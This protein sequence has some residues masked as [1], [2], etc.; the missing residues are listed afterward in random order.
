[1]TIRATLSSR[2]RAVTLATGLVLLLVAATAVAANNSTTLPNGAQLSVSVDAPADGAQLLADGGPLPVAVSGTAGIGLGDPKATIVYVFDASGSTTAGGGACG[3]VLACEQAFFTGLNT[4]ATSGGSVNQ[5][6]LVAFGVDAVQADMTSAGGDDLLGA[7]GDANTVISSITVAVG[8][9]QVGQY[10]PKG[11]NASGT[12]FAAALQQALGVL[13]ASTDPSK[14]VVFASDGF[15]NL[16]TLTDFNDAVAAIAATGAVVN[17]VAIGASSACTGGTTGTLAGLAVNGGTCYAVTDPN[18]LPD[19]IPALIGS[20]LE[21]VEMSVDGGTPVAVATTPATPQ[22]GHAAVAYSTSTAGLDPGRHD[23]CATA[24]GTDVTGGSA[25]TTACV[26]VGVYDLELAPATATNELGSDDT[27]T[28]TATLQGPAGAVDGY[29]VSFSVGGQNA[30]AA[31][32][33]VPADCRTNAGGQV[34]FTYSVPIAQSSLGVDTITA[35]VTLAD[36]AGETDTEQVTK[37]WAD[38]TAPVV[39]C[40]PTTNPSGKNTPPAGSNPKSGQNPDGFY[41]LTAV[42]AVDPSPLV[43]IADTGSGFVAGPY[44]SGT[45]IKLVQAPG[46]TPSARPGPGAIDWHVTLKGD[47]S[48]TATDASGNTSTATCRVP[49]PPK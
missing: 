14:F 5:V 9:Y 23:I 11:G 44:P 7:P 17:S 2:S 34:T 31:G 33:C 10:T 22:P 43:T 40:A 13:T 27:H 4:A 18:D 48:V 32:A 1:M 20:T 37:T 45:T 16:G 8:P 25:D 38:T 46:A 15:S 24:F 49:P 19:I 12:N 36:P 42:D 35:E 41:V 30:G 47:A 39:T 29:L 21:K 28:V 6:G 3:S 26:A